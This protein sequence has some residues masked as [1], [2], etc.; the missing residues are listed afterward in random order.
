MSDQ[1]ATPEMTEVDP[2][3]TKITAAWK[4][5]KKLE[6]ELT[7][8]QNCADA[9]RDA[10]ETSIQ[11]AENAELEMVSGNDEFRKKYEHQR[12]KIRRHRRY[13]DKLRDAFNGE[14][15]KVLTFRD[16]LEDIDRATKEESLPVILASKP[17][18]EAW[19]DTPMSHMSKI[20]KNPL[21]ETV[22]NKLIDAGY[23]TLGKLTDYKSSGSWYTDIDG[24]GKATSDKIDDAVEQFFA[25]WN[26]MASA[27]AS[28]ESGAEPNNILETALAEVDGIPVEAVK[29][30]KAEKIESLA[31]L[32]AK[33]TEMGEDAPLWLDCLVGKEE[34]NLVRQSIQKLAQA[35]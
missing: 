24:I 6:K 17:M 9:Q 31:D 10:L 27:A 7:D 28:E 23:D 22:V 11:A 21:S 15:K 26:A 16:E 35:A 25:E 4:R 12:E 8:Q 20:S 19:R 13:M 33:L 3:I 18:N 5:V 32:Q 29:Q 1:A 30:L 2:R 34:A 14:K